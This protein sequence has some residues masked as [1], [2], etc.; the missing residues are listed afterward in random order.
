MNALIQT[1]ATLHTLYQNVYRRVVAVFPHGEDLLLSIE[2]VSVSEPEQLVQRWIFPFVL[3]LGDASADTC[4]RVN[5]LLRF[6]DVHIYAEVG[7]SMLHLGGLKTLDDI[8][9]EMLVLEQD[10]GLHI[11]RQYYR[12]LFLWLGKRTVIE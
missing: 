4:N 12:P 7:K 2:R 6:S 3:Y 8:W 9:L 5:T 11:Y 10:D 1:C